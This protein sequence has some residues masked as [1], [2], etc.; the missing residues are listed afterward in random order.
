MSFLSTIFRISSGFFLYKFGPHFFYLRIS[1]VSKTFDGEG[2]GR[3]TPLAGYA[4]ASDDYTPGNKTV[5]KLVP[6]NSVDTFLFFFCECR[7]CRFVHMTV[8]SFKY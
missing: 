4:T 6:M 8:S 5:F 7:S 3:A 1:W 2:G